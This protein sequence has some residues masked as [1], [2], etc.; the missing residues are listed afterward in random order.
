MGSVLKCTYCIH[1]NLNIW[2]PNKCRFTT[3]WM[4]IIRW[5]A[6]EHIR[7]RHLPRHP[8]TAVNTRQS[9]SLLAA[10]CAG[11]CSFSFLW[12]TLVLGIL[13]YAHQKVDWNTAKILWNF[14]WIFTQFSFSK[15]FQSK[16]HPTSKWRKFSIYCVCLSQLFIHSIRIDWILSFWV[17]FELRNE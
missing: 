6:S 2:F 1:G 3:R 7:D 8:S 12:A 16:F 13:Y 10:N 15:H 11:R 9:Q 5:L 17:N 14:D 4:T